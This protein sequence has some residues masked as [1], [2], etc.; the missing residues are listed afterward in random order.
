[1]LSSRLG[2]CLRR[3]G[4]PS[5]NLEASS[6]CSRTLMT[7]SVLGAQGRNRY[8][9]GGSNRQD[10]SPETKELIRK[11]RDPEDFSWQ[12]GHNI[13]EPVTLDLRTEERTRALQYEVPYRGYAAKTDNGTDL[14]KYYPYTGEEMPDS[15]PSPVLMVTKVKSLQGEPYWVKDYCEQIGLSRG[16]RTNKEARKLGKRVF[17]PNLPSVG[18]LLY[19]IKHVVDIQPVTFP[20]GMPED[21][22]PDRHGFKINHKGEFTVEGPPKE[23]LESIAARADWMKIDKEHYEREARKHWDAPFNSPLGNSNYHRKNGYL[24]NSKADSEFVK[25]Q[26]K[27]WS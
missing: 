4:P 15:P 17:L 9:K 21:F 8:V 1:M 14:I 26:R 7:S 3:L 23:S 24:Y 19:K 20:N 6:V 11:A 22:D 16:I 25:N 2:Q 10:I 27:K 5:S 12:L 18:H 13:E